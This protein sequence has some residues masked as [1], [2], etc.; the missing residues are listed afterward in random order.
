MAW[1]A[2]NVE[3][4]PVL[5]VTVEVPPF[6]AMLA[7]LTEM[8]STG[9][10]SSS[11]IAMLCCVPTAFAPIAASTRI[12]SASSSMMSSMP[13]TVVLTVETSSPEPAGSVSDFEPIA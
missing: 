4:A 3:P 11:A 6:S 12:V 1:S 7:V 13:V 8:P 9:A 5:T 2:A 10:A